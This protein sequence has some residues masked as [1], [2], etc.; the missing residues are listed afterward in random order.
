MIEF[1]SSDSADLLV[2][3]K[4]RE[5]IDHRFALFGQRSLLAEN[6]HR[7]KLST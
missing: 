2:V 4:V 3:F 6:L 1:G 5:G 7:G